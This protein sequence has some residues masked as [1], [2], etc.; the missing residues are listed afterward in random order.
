MQ[1]RRALQQAQAGAGGGGGVVVA[2][3]P[4]AVSDVE[5]ER[6]EVGGGDMH[7]QHQMQEFAAARDRTLQELAEQ[8]ALL[9]Q[10]YEECEVCV[11]ENLLF[12]PSFAENFAP[13]KK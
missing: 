4:V 1:L 11:F 12:S 2:Q 9:Q 3:T 5:P 13:P 10:Q 7:V 8:K 6:E